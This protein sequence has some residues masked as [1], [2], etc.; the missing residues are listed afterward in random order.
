MTP[1]P[2]PRWKPAVGV[3]GAVMAGLAAV[4]YNHPGLRLVDFLGFSTRGNRLLG[5]EDLIN[6]LYPAGYPFVVG[7]LQSALESPILAGRILSILAAGLTALVTARW[8]GPI[9]ALWLAVQP[10]L[11]TFGSTEGTDLAA[12]SLA[13]AAVWARSNRHPV[14][15]GVL[16]G[17]AALTRYTA[18]AAFPVVLL[19][20]LT[21]PRKQQ[22]TA[23]VLGAF[24]LTTTP[25]WAV[26]LATGAPVL[27][28]QS[29]NFAIGA[30]AV[31][32]GFGWD[33]LVRMPAGLAAAVP[34]VFSGPGVVLGTVALVGV[35]I[36]AWKRKT[37]G[38]FEPM[39][40]LLGWGAM[41]LVLVSAAFANARLVLPTRLIL[42][43]GL[44]VALRS[45]PRVLAACTLGF[46]LWTVPP[47]WSPSDGEVRLAG[48]VSA[49][50]DLE[51]PLRT[52]HFLTSDPWVYR[53]NG[54]Y[55]QSGT[56]LR[57][58][59][60][61]PRVLDGP[62][63]ATF[64]R[65]RGYSLVVLDAGRVGRTYPGL[66]PVLQHPDQASAAGLSPLQRVPGYRVFAV[67]PAQESK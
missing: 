23:K 31:V 38:H 37:L 8:L 54:A 11:L 27:P 67:T 60:G 12:F 9:A 16:I 2:P 1:A 4:S 59:G 36:V 40:R 33:T 50:E 57:E 5:G 66:A 41:H 21:E 46:A 61:D 52:G 20:A 48:V 32:H 25:H 29:G 58:V 15:A 64:A 18:A 28:D 62:T 13:L 6:P 65:A 17:L 43:L 14:A 24:L 53:Q 51:G 30:N 3:A 19:P 10:V 49:L 44:P 39:A 56:P 47:A 22:S 45:H 26:A 7:V 42:A 55:L 34:F 63:L 35:A